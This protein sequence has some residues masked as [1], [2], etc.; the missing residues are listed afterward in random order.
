[1]VQSFKTSKNLSF[2]KIKKSQPEGPAFTLHFKGGM[3]ITALSTMGIFLR[4]PGE[5][6]S[7]PGM[8][9]GQGQACISSVCEGDE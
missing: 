5:L 8:G 9:E 4:N 6:L 7:F 2:C 1:M 3:G